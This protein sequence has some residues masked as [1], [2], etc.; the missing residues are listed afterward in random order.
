MKKYYV[1]GNK[2]SNSLSPTIFNYWFKKYNI[3]AKYGYLEWKNESFD[4]LIKK[5][6]LDKSIFGLNVTIPFKQKVMKH[7]QG[8]D[9]HSKKINAVNCVSIKKTTTGFNTD[10]NGYYKTLPEKI[11]KKK[12]SKILLIGYGGAALAIHYVL[13]QKGFTNIAIINRSRKKLKFINKTRF[14]KNENKI[15]LYLRGVD[16]VI[17]TT[18]K[19]PIKN[20]HRALISE[21]TFLSDINYKPK[22]TSFLK[23]FS[24]NKKIYGISMLIEQAI[25]C[26]N[27]W[28]GFKPSVDKK[29]INILEKKIK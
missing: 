12:D 8:L 26:F 23:Q 15:N 19:N 11:K 25:P 24:K 20:K 18:P 2:T 29:L 16:L 1:I 3:K 7:L 27:L 6:L 21:K 22:E 4:K 14:T 9:K 10:W 17:N 5:T 13:I 28:F